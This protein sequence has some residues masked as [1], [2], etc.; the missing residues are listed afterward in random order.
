MLCDVLVLEREQRLQHVA[1]ALRRLA[2]RPD[3][4]LAV[5]PL[6]Q[7]VLRFERRVRDEGI[8]VGAFNDLGR[9]LE[10][11]IRVAVLAHGEAGCGLR[12][13]LGSLG[14]SHAA[15]R[16]R[17]P[18]VPGDLQFLARAVRLPPTVG[19]NRDAPE[20]AA[21]IIAAVNDK[22][23]AH[24]WLR[25]DD[26]EIG[27]CDFAAKDRALLEHGRQ[28]AGHREV[29]RVDRLAGDNGLVVDAGRGLTD[30]GVVLGILQCDGAKVGRRQ[31]RGCRRQF[32]VAERAVRRAMRHATGGRGAV[33]VRHTPRLRGSRGQHHP[34]GGAG[35]AQRFPV[36]R[37][38]RA[39]ARVLRSVFRRIEIGLLQA[40]VLPLDA[41]FLGNQHRH[42]RLDALS[43]FRVLGDDGDEIVGRDANE[44]V[45]REVASPC[46]E[47]SRG[48]LRERVADAVER[49]GDHE[50]AA[51][52]C[53]DAEE[54][55]AVEGEWRHGYFSWP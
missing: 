41:E 38:A 9:R 55:A 22:G 45:G 18:L 4:E 36:G 53:A 30:N 7:A 32:A 21:E 42:R 31:G 52:E 25:L 1:A 12:E 23:V 8:R 15:L 44:R 54:R 46:P 16:C 11:G 3:L 14:K 17:R 13:L 34:A 19:D 33:T 37:R 47:R 48:G 49:G 5:L 29:D 35:A 50:A 6:R 27:G 28:H 20:Q 2:G 43:H 51:S 10:R 40:H 26:I 24:A 39:A